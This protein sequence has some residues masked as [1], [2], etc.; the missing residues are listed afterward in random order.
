M[1]TEQAESFVH[2]LTLSFKGEDDP[3]RELTDAERAA[4][5][6]AHELLREIRRVPGLTAAQPKTTDEGD[7]VFPKGEVDESKLKDWVTAARS[8]SQLS[9]RLKV[10][11]SMIGQI[12]AYAPD[13]A[14]E[15][16]PCIPVRNLIEEIASDEL[17]YG[18]AIGVHNKRGVHFVEPGGKQEL[19]LAA[20][21]RGYADAIRSRWPRTG[22]ILA[23]IAK[24]YERE[25][26]DNIEREQFGE[27]E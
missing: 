18:L 21:F 16:W 11:D 1:V 22:Q 14:D 8:S 10:C 25:A 26:T 19:R 23:H 6:Q 9:R 3:P 15:I 27:F 7:V 4:G 24:G 2:L 5:Q 13:D 17:D 20:K 12:L